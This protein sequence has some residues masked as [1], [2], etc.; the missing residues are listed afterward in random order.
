M[1]K[2]RRK[3]KIVLL[4]KYKTHA[5]IVKTLN[6]NILNIHVFSLRETLRN[7]TKIGPFLYDK[8]DVSHRETDRSFLKDYKGHKFHKERPPI[9]CNKK[10]PTQII[11]LSSYYFNR[12]RLYT[13]VPQKCTILS[14]KNVHF[15]TTRMYI[16]I[17]IDNQQLT[18]NH[19]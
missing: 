17:S 16:L 12:T 15:H 9:I 1:A 18:N 8:R 4:R 6:I 11:K 13:L 2:K 3:R 5:K 14:Y 10:R 19:K 7:S